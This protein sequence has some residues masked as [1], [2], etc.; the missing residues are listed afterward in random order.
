MDL[1]TLA[2]AI[3]SALGFVAW[4]IIGNY[5]GASGGWVATIMIWGTAIVITLLSRNELRNGSLPNA[6][7]MLILLFAGVINGAAVYCY[8][9]KAADKKVDTAAFVIAVSILMIM[10]APVLDWAL[11]GTI[12][13]PRKIG[14]FVLAAFVVYVLSE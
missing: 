12:P 14:G 1:K 10:W 3:F 8:A 5:S 6:R 2:V 13:T 9:L 7:A 4:P 11:K